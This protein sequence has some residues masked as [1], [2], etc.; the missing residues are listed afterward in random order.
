MYQTMTMPR[1][2]KPGPSVYERVA[3]S[4]H[5]YFGADAVHYIARL[6]EIHTRKHP[7]LLSEAELISL[8]DWIKSA[9]LF[10]AED[11]KVAEAYMDRLLDIADGA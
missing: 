4:T 8:L 5:E 2:I 9:I 6:I 10:F 3:Q 11:A 1:K 7:E